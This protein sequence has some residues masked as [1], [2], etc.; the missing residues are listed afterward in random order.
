[1]L[2]V[3][4]GIVPADIKVLRRRHTAT[5]QTMG[6]PRDARSE[7]AD[8]TARVYTYAKRGGEARHCSVC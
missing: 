8:P 7:V 3:A 1:M 2:R 6:G 5:E 4:T